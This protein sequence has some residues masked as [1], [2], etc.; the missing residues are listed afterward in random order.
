MSRKHAPVPNLPGGWV[1]VV[2]GG[3]REGGREAE[4]QQQS[5]ASERS[6]TGPGVEI[7]P[8][9][10]IKQVK[11][12]EFNW[13]L[14]IYDC[15]CIME[16]YKRPLRWMQKL[17]EHHLFGVWSAGSSSFSQLKYK[18]C[19]VKGIS[20]ITGKQRESESSVLEHPT[21]VMHSFEG[22]FYKVNHRMY[23]T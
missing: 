20:Q 17:C 18:C 4:Q 5:A 1:V 7:R 11:W 12:V 6:P 15:I 8:S 9:C 16:M 3:G 2:G 10:A 14:N 22:L 23:C 13:R 21:T 19:W